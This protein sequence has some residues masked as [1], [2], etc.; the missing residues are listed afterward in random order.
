MAPNPFMISKASSLTRKASPGLK[1]FGK[2]MGSQISRG[3]RGFAKKAQKGFNS[4]NNS[5][6]S[7]SSY[8]DGASYSSQ[9]ASMIYSNT[10]YWGCLIAM[11]VSIALIFIGGLVATLSTKDDE[12]SVAAK[13]MSIFVIVFAV[14]ALSISFFFYT[15]R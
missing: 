9:G 2:S 5:L 1:K 4:M 8:S 6:S 3:S 10:Y 14:F 15:R 11:L 12:T 13:K 7:S